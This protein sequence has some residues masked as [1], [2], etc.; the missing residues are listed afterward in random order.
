MRWKWI[1]LAPLAI[2]AMLLFIT[3]GG[4]WFGMWMSQ[5]WNGAPDAFWHIRQ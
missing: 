3:I 1:F 2:L 5:Q 4:E